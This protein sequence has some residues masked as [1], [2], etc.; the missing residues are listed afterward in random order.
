MIRKQAMTLDPQAKRLLAMMSVTSGAN[1]E[2]EDIAARRRAFALMMDLTGCAVAPEIFAK[3]IAIPGPGG[4]LT[5]RLY[6]PPSIR[7]APSPAIVYLH[8][9]GWVSGN[10]DTHDAVCRGLADAGGF[11]VIAVDYR[12]APEHKHPAALDDAAAATKW[13]IEN[14]LSLDIDPSRIAIS[15]DSAGA[16]LAASL[17]Y[18][19]AQR[20][21]SPFALQIL[22]CPF[23]DLA[24]ETP[25]REAFGKGYFLD[26]QAMKRDFVLCFADNSV[27]I[28]PSVSPLRASD[29][30]RQPPAHIHS[31]EF[32]PVRD[33]GAI[34]ASRL[35]DAGVDVHYVCHP[36]MIHQ[37]YS[38][39]GIIPYAL[40]ALNNIGAAAGSALRQEDPLA[41][42][43]LRGAPVRT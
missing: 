3:D 10:L 7:A 27:L 32:D 40:T 30:S 14:A 17:C 6:I 26:L 21:L 43:T 23:L 38:M 33:E 42:P 13:V 20:G 5:L 36:G 31:A 1:A 16:N 25:S 9:G 41:C 4:A 2:I 29:F 8:G 12:L 19:F 34:Y 18:R 39:G 35:R 37:F 22:L 24:A 15:G 28:D 11:R